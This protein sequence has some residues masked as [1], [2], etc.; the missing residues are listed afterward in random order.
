MFSALNKWIKI[1]K[2]S[3]K[4]ILIFIL[5]M[6]TDSIC[7]ISIPI[8]YA[9]T[10]SSVTAQNMRLSYLWASTIF[11]T[12]ILG[13]IIQSVKNNVFNNPQ[14]ILYEKLNLN[15]KY[16][17]TEKQL[18][19]DFFNSMS[20][21]LLFVFKITAILII[22]LVYSPYLTLFTTLAIIICLTVSFIFQLKTLKENQIANLKV[23][24]ECLWNFFTFILLIK[25]I[26]LFSSSNITLSAFL[27]LSGFVNTHLLKPNFPVDI[28]ARTKH[29][30]KI[31]QK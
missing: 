1:I 6:L 27:L 12:Q 21:L 10:I 22:S 17:L 8:S 9:N 2:P 14:N 4:Q 7:Y 19:I 11:L 24:I 31:L 30:N 29:L 5:I 20:D 28:I 3:K 23:I 15:K 13:L 26:N 18:F 16:S 25:I